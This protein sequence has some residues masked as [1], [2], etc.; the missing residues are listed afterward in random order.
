MNYV[1]SELDANGR[2]QDGNMLFEEAARNVCCSNE[3]SAINSSRATHEMGC[4]KIQAVRFGLFY[5]WILMKDLAFAV[6]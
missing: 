2:K 4:V 3:V 5:C 6:S 1:W